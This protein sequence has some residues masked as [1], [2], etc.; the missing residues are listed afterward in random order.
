M[1]ALS[2]VVVTSLVMST[3]LL[4]P[5]G[6][7]AL[8]AT[9]ARQ[10]EGM[11]TGDQYLLGEWVTLTGSITF[12]DAEEQSLTS[13]VLEV[14]GPD[15][16]D[17]I[18]DITLP[19]EAG[20]HTMQNGRLIVT[21]THNN[22][23]A[24][25]AED[26]YGYG[27]GYGYAT[28]DFT[29]GA[30]GGSIDYI[31][32]WRPPYLLQNPDAE[33]P[34]TDLAWEIP[35]ATGISASKKPL[36]MT[37]DETYLYILVDGASW[38][39]ADKILKTDFN[40][41]LVEQ[42]DA[43]HSQT[44]AIAYANNNLYVYADN[45]QRIFSVTGA[46]VTEG[47]GGMWGGDNSDK[48]SLD[49]F[50]GNNSNIVQG[51]LVV[52]SSI[53]GVVPTTGFDQWDG[54]FTVVT[55]PAWDDDAVSAPSVLVVNGT[56]YMYYHSDQG[57]GASDKIG[58]AESADGVNWV[59]VSGNPVLEGDTGEWDANGV[60]NP[61]VI[62][63][64]GSY[65]MWYIA[66]AAV[67]YATSTD[68]V[69]WTK[70][71]ANPVHEP[72]PG[73]WDAGG[74]QDVNVISA[75]GFTMYYTAQGEF[76]YAPKIGYATNTS[77]NGVT[78]EELSKTTEL[79][80]ANA[81][82]PSVSS[83]ST[84]IAA[85][86]DGDLIVSDGSTTTNIT[87]SWELATT[88]DTTVDA[89]SND[90][91]W[92]GDW[93]EENGGSWQGAAMLAT[94]LPD[95][96][97]TDE[98]DSSFAWTGD[99]FEENDSG[100]NEGSAY[101]VSGLPDAIITDEEDSSFAWTG[102]WFEDDTQW[103]NYNDDAAQYVDDLP[104]DVKTEETDSSF[105]F[106]GSWTSYDDAGNDYMQSPH[107][108]EPGTSVAITF[109]GTEVAL[110]YFMGND[111][112]TVSV[113]IDGTAYNNLNMYGQHWDQKD[114]T[115]ADDLST[116]SHTLTLT[117][118]NS[119]HSSS[120][121]YRIPIDGV[122]VPNPTANSVA[123]TFTGTEVAL[124]YKE[125]TDQGI[126][127]VDIDGTAYDNISMYNP[128]GG[129][130]SE[131]I[132]DDLSNEEH[133]LTITQL[134][135]KH[136]SS[137]GYKVHIDGIEQPNPTANSVA[138]TF[139]G[140][141][142]ALRYKGGDQ[143]GQVSLD[144]DGTS[145]DDFDTYNNQGHNFET[146]TVAD[147]LSNEEHVLTVT[148]LET[149]NSSSNNYQIYIDGI[150]QPNPT[151]NS[152]SITFSG[153]GVTL[154]YRESWQY[155][156]LGVVIDG[157]TYDT[158]D[159]Y[160]N[161]DDQNSENIVDDLPAGS[162]T[163]VLT[164]L[165]SKNSNSSGNTVGIDAIVITSPATQ[166]GGA[167]TTPVWHPT[168]ADVIAFVSDLTGDDQIFE[169]DL[170]GGVGSPTF[171]RVTNSSYDSNQ[172]T[173]SPDGTMIAY[174]GKGENQNAKVLWTIG[175]ASGGDWGSSRN[176]TEGHWNAPH[177]A[178]AWH[179]GGEYIVLVS[180]GN[181]G[182]I[183]VDQS[184]GMN[185]SWLN[186]NGSEV[187]EGGNNSLP[188]WS[189]DG[190]QL[191]FQKGGSSDKSIQV[192]Q[193]DENNLNNVSQTVTEFVDDV[194]AV[195]YQP[196]YSPDGNWVY[197][198][199][200]A[201][202]SGTFDI[203]RSEDAPENPILTDSDFWFA[204]QGVSEPSVIYDGSTYRMWLAAISSNQTKS[205]GYA[206]SNDGQSWQ[207]GGQ[208]AV[209]ES[210]WGGGGDD[211]EDNA[212]LSPTVV[213]ESGLEMWYVGL[214]QQGDPKIGKAIS[215]NGASWSRDQSNPVL[216]GGATLGTLTASY[217]YTEMHSWPENS[218][219]KID[220]ANS[221][222]YVE[223]SQSPNQQSLGGLGFDGQL[224]YGRDAQGDM[225]YTFPPDNINSWNE[226]WISGQGGH[227][228]GGTALVA[229]S[230]TTLYASPTG[231]IYLLEMDQ[232]QGMQQEEAYSTGINSISGLAMIQSTMYIGYTN[233]L[234][235]GY[236]STSGIPGTVKL[237]TTGDYDSQLVVNEGAATST[238]QE[239]TLNELSDPVSVTIT[240]PADGAA[241]FTPTI[242]IEG[243]V[244]DPSIDTVQVGIDLPM[245]LFFEDNMEN[246]DAISSDEFSKEGAPQDG[247]ANYSNENL[248]HRSTKYASSGSSSFSY[249]NANGYGY[250]T[251]GMANSGSIVSTPFN[252]GQD[253]VLT[254]STAWDTDPWVDVDRKLIDI[255]F[256]SGWV[257]LAYIVDGPWYHD[258][259]NGN[260]IP[261][262][263]PMAWSWD[264]MGQK[265]GGGPSWSWSEVT[266]DFTQEGITD[267]NDVRLRFRMDTMDDFMNDMEGWFIDSVRVSGA[268]FLGFNVPVDPD[269]LVW[270][271][272]YQLAEG[273]NTISVA[274]QSAY[275]VGQTGND[276]ESVT[277]SLDTTVPIISLD[278]YPSTNEGMVDITG[279]VYE[280]NFDR[281]QIKRNGA[282]ISTIDSV[283][284][285]EAAPDWD[286]TV[287]VPLVDGENEIVADIWDV[288]NASADPAPA[289]AS[290]T[291]IRDAAAPSL[292]VLPTVFY[293]GGVSARRGDLFIFQ[294]NATD[295]GTIPSGVR[296]VEVRMPG[297][298][299]WE[300]MIPAH[301]LPEAFRDA[302]G[303]IGQYL[304]PMV[305]P[306][307]AAP[308]NYEMEIRATDFA[309]NTGSGD[310]NLLAQVVSTLSEYNIY[311]MPNWNFFSVPLTPDS[312]SIE[313]LMGGI[314]G[315]KSVQYF[316][317]ASSTWQ[318]YTPDG[319]SLNDTLSVI[320]T[321][322]GYWADMDEG[323]FDFSAPFDEGLPPTPSPILFNYTGEVLEPGTVPPTYDVYDGWN[324]I[325]IHS[326][327]A[328]PV[329]T[330]LRPVS[331]PQQTWAALLQY[332]NYITVDVVRLL[333]KIFGD[334][335]NQ[336]NNNGDDDESSPYEIYLGSFRTLLETDDM[337]PAA[338]FW[339]YLTQDGK[340]VAMP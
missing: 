82:H 309:G 221:G 239:F 68:G 125:G 12:G 248:W 196:A 74:I 189:A 274:G 254:F 121:G 312:T 192:L 70:N 54:S 66:S 87:Q 253:T 316:D 5:F 37:S 126:V 318:V 96:I 179:P 237:D 11:L 36:G 94:D 336:I 245:I 176:V 207:S 276:L 310:E 10:G 292:T 216:Q 106:T 267:V 304:L 103:E 170:S 193:W 1:K 14:D 48:Y 190:T 77:G 163:M 51:S 328:K 90:I 223:H 233:N 299:N 128:N 32:N 277:V 325:G 154:I 241:Y 305:V 58:L 188:T 315:L 46:N 100:A 6:A 297:D 132:A 127:S 104:A 252:I 234:G 73:E 62:Y 105:A 279:S 210:Q 67:G 111:N 119:K 171:S 260:R 294:A 141:E 231:T 278:P 108:Y 175:P 4:V 147:D 270:E 242:D 265:F 124:R 266:I 335:N 41:N 55:D 109:S 236:V 84:R 162:H 167:E 97:T 88:E 258:P 47:G 183:T 219:I 327:W 80:L 160:N 79:Y 122:S 290:I 212:V 185:S 217:S 129:N 92:T 89:D 40:G 114:K 314:T 283:P 69:N 18:D 244:N 250:S 168:D 95:A 330:Y 259:F 78:W 22:V 130:T 143:H 30:G 20:V 15:P 42:Y 184:G 101:Y 289:S 135:T 337:N 16:V 319:N 13:V 139:T 308:G 27:Y 324:A 138:I 72:T 235:T 7:S 83:D 156:E 251:P 64:S 284:E 291:V 140:T 165:E 49:N 148:Q 150:E 340:L 182:Y 45:Y 306:N 303:T 172:P 232:H 326:E 43:P 24:V 198:A 53:E 249:S 19:T 246:G 247:W 75:N 98:E 57:F 2:S 311:L 34:A 187:A 137:N 63:D 9:L 44:N 149:K 228:N 35:D 224:L 323:V 118:I 288:P 307:D 280:L 200:D 295:Q 116:G 144:I 23:S 146:Y 29:G 302:W 206:T 164:Q 181:I 275:N 281:M 33:L 85:I 201:N 329:D 152:A 28:Y 203:W 282:L 191:Y 153:T 71:G 243:T 133:V 338:G 145:Y 287:G 174:S 255:D 26:G 199:S 322:R 117:Q 8:T 81:E 52:T 272:E 269:T 131:T 136:N 211:W 264:T 298:D 112:G 220:P 39:G 155:G 91:S 296:K 209:L 25:Q 61:S 166:S 261:L 110:N 215:G 151:R 169:V 317:A 31:I 301:Q 157:T 180:N 21:V 300:H 159:M 229:Q 59:K 202:V 60:S 225:V 86:R 273:V 195:D 333:N 204:E 320:Y 226:M 285:G 214:N 271:T 38:D 240:T 123:I 120:N 208:N 65:H 293:L 3:L 134:T 158:I 321:G 99:W 332:D 227:Y 238:E 178:P 76:S 93:D 339:L 256:G 102:D 142:V 107:D 334:E 161:W 173:Y 194:G 263:V 205:I 257:P 113:D 213:M 331:V 313:T 56:Y 222:E 186:N 197:Y 268:G 262:Y 286:F 50:D 230:S 115:I 218:I 177:T 17:D